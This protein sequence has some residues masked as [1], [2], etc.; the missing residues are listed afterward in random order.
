MATSSTSTTAVVQPTMRRVRARR[1]GSVNTHA[2]VRRVDGDRGGELGRLEPG[3]RAG[4]GPRV[5]PQPGQRGGRA[6]RA[7][8]G[9]RRSAGASVCQ[10]SG[11]ESRVVRSCVMCPP[12]SAQCCHCQ[13]QYS[14][15]M[16]TMSTPALVRIRRDGPRH[17]PAGPRRQAAR[18]ATT[19]AI[20]AA[21]CVAGGAA[22][23]SRP[24]ASRPDAPRASARR[25]ASREPRSTAISPT[26]RR[27]SP[28]WRA[29]A[30][31]R[32]ASS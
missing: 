25:S 6:R 21:R 10:R 29:R 15:S 16:L 26:S 12:P 17:A 32:S 8:A 1:A 20:C 9:R 14:R 27:C 11:D 3:G 4:D 2:S 28:R 7:S 31:A 5:E 30:S 18:A 19:T 22:R 23:R 13:H 24:T